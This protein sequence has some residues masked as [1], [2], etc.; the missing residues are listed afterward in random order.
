MAAQLTAA[1]S[2]IRAA[3]ADV[4]RLRARP[5]TAVAIDQLRADLSLAQ[6]GFTFRDAVRQEQE[7]VYSLAAQSDLESATLPLI[8]GAPATQ[9]SQAD[10]GLRAL[11][12]L[13]GIES[14]APVHP[15][16]NKRFADSEPPD[17]LLGYYRAAGSRNGVDWTYLAAINFIESDLGRNLGPSSA[18]ALGPMQFLPTTFREYGGGGDIMS[19]HDSIQAAA[20]LLARNGAP[21]DYDR[22]LM[23]YNH[24]Q[25]YVTAVKAYAAAMRGDALWLT[26]FYYWSTYG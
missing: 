10:Q 12:R 8:G 18:G 26:R 20:L 24:S 19:A 23:R 16:Y 13:V 5:A 4:D 7:L 21:G 3:S 22:A 25:D 2:A 15:R 1:G 17:A 9:V 6:A 14:G 11:W